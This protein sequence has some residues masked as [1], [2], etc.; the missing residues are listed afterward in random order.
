MVT[1]NPSILIVF[2]LCMLLAA[3]GGSSEKPSNDTSKADSG[4]S[5]RVDPSRVMKQTPAAEIL[6][7]T[8]QRNLRYQPEEETNQIMQLDTL[9]EYIRRV[10]LSLRR[11]IG[12]LQPETPSAGTVVVGLN[13]KGE[14]RLWYVFPEGQPSEP[15]KAAANAAIAAVPKPTLKKSLIVFGVALTLWGYQET[16]REAKA[17]ELPKEWKAITEA[18][19][20]PQPATK[21][22]EM[23]WNQVVN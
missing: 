1:R 2:L 5:N 16:D 6:G 21:L 9:L 4:A 10:G 22:A 14:N 12:K 23:T 13:A 11:E 20:S 18:S 7:S 8:V 15:F 17:V 3:C 19:K